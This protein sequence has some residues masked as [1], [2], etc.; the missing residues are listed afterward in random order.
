[1]R[2]L[3]FVASLVAGSVAVAPT[4]ALTSGH[5][6]SGSNP[7]N[8]YG[9]CTAANNGD[10][11]GWTKQGSVPPPFQSL[12]QAGENTNDGNNDTESGSDPRAD[13]LQQC[14]NL[15]VTP[16]GQGHGAP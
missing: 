3:L 16:G 14:S 2:R 12:S 7:P 1:M 15:G 6:P 5:G 11:N 13:V 10:K 8:T 9:H 4:V